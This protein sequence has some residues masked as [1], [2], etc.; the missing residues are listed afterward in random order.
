VQVSCLITGAW[1][2]AG[3]RASDECKQPGG[4]AFGLSIR[5]IVEVMDAELI[6]RLSHD[7]HSSHFRRVRPIRSTKSLTRPIVHHLQ[8]IH[9]PLPTP[10]HA[11]QPPLPLSSHCIHPYS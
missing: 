4:L 9:L 10:P 2:Q 5:F 11:Y 6:S 3:G 8:N 1:K 7:I